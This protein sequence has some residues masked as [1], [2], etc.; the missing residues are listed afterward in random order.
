MT[1]K[2]GEYLMGDWPPFP[3]HSPLKQSLFTAT[4]MA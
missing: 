3:C 1:S 2:R 4:P